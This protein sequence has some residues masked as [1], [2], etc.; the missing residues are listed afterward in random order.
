MK[1][2]SKL[3]IM[4]IVLA[5]VLTACVQKPAPASSEEDNQTPE[6]SIAELDVSIDFLFM[7]GWGDKD[8]PIVKDQLEKAGFKVNLVQVPDYASY[9][10]KIESGSYDMAF[11]GWTTVTGNP[12]YAVRSLFTPD[13]DYNNSG[14]NNKDVTNAIM[15]A[16]TLT[17]EEYV[18]VYNEMEKKL[19]DE[20]L[21]VPLYSELRGLAYNSNVLKDTVRLSKSRS[22]VWESYD[23]VDESKRDTEHVVLSQSMGNLTSLDPIKGNDGSINM[24]N[25]NIY[26]RLVNLTDDD[27]VIPDGSLSYQFAIGENNTEYYFILR[28]DITFAALKDGKVIDTGELVA[29]EDVVAHLSRANDKNSVEGHRTYTLHQSMK[30]ISMITDISEL[31]NAITANGKSVKEILEAGI[32]GGISTLVDNK[33]DV[34]NSA[35]AYQVIKIETKEPFPQ[36]LN[37][38][39]HQSA[40]IVKADYVAQINGNG[41]NYGD[42]S[43]IG[44]DGTIYA[45][46]PYIITS[47]NDQVISFEKN[48]GYRT[49]S[50]FEPK[51]KYIDIKIIPDR[52]A[53][54]QAL[55]SEEIHLVYRPNEAHIEKI[56]ADEK[57]GLKEKESNATVYLIFNLNEEFGSVMLDENLRHAVLNAIDV[58]PFID[59]VKSGKAVPISSTVTPLIKNI[60]G[61]KEVVKPTDPA[62]VQEYINKYLES[63]K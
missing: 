16:A 14:I 55:F 46:G 59:I 54:I 15:K 27:K 37:F 47:K 39:A 26:V 30:E 8:A 28:D 62:K 57:L 13:G 63:K 45:S 36:V 22:Q 10:E 23:L 35:G 31:E 2:R 34:D 38:L 58:K 4:L 19:L 18:L 49:G 3:F 25:T 42:Q 7:S 33:N 50:Q 52:N 61:Y 5:L 20:A 21:I 53:E 24:I 51:V 32:D 48:P 6:E 12:D 11:T 60:P 1:K 40:G 44:Q 41:G 29:G 56:K 17:P 9:V 43:T